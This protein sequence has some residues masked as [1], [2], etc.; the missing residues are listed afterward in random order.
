MKT[1]SL[2]EMTF[3]SYIPPI[4]PAIIFN[5]FTN[6]HGGSSCPLWIKSN[7]HIER[8]GVTGTHSTP[9]VGPQWSL[10]GTLEMGIGKEDR[11]Q[12]LECPEQEEGNTY[13]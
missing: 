1:T 5:Y 6:I 13:M 3:L 2:S 12:I 4:L 7:S 11:P 10:S 9:E 8:L